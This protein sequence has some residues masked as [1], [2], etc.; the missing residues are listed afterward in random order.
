MQVLEQPPEER[1]DCRN[2]PRE[3]ERVRYVIK[4]K[5]NC[6]HLRPSSPTR[7][8]ILLTRSRPHSESDSS[9]SLFLPP[10]RIG[11]PP[12]TRCLSPPQARPRMGAVSSPSLTP[13]LAPSRPAPSQT[14][15][16]DARSADKAAAVGRQRQRAP[17]P[18]L[19]LSPTHPSKDDKNGNL[20]H[21]DSQNFRTMARDKYIQ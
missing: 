21:H 9:P 11:T 6:R 20:F 18:F 19:S 13:V 5:I 4:F 1:K 15:P 7:T 3:R 12:I 10:A 2:G 14:P 8:R 16:P 17:P